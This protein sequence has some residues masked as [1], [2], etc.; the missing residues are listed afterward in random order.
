MTVELTQTVT[1]FGGCKLTRHYDGNSTLSVDQQCGTAAYYDAVVRDIASNNTEYYNSGDGTNKYWKHMTLHVYAYPLPY[2]APAAS[3]L[4]SATTE[5]F[6]CFNDGSDYAHIDARYLDPNNGNSYRYPASLSHEF[7]HGWHDWAGLQRQGQAYDE[8]RA[9][10][11]RRF[12]KP[13]VTS[14]PNG[15]NI[16]EA[17]ANAWRCQRGVAATRGIPDVPDTMENP[18]NHPEWH[19]QDNLLPELCA[20]LASIGSTIKA[21]TLSW[22]GDDTTGFW[23][24]QRTDGVWVSQ[25]NYYGWREWRQVNNWWEPTRWDWVQFS[26][27][28]DRQ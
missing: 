20:Y 26:P 12:L 13:G 22:Q 15:Y 16:W 11:T 19:K 3:F 14:Y 18:N 9:F 28:Y 4:G 17:F 6:C 27:T 1:I 8:L 5:A 21:G 2:E 24:F 10:Y 23:Q 7:G 25:N